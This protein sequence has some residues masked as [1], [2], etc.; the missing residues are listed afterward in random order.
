VAIGSE[1]GTVFD[2]I[3]HASGVFLAWGKYQQLFLNRPLCKKYLKNCPSSIFFQQV[4]IAKKSRILCFI[5]NLTIPWRQKYF[6]KAITTFFYVN[7][8][9][10]ILGGG[11]HFGL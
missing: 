6:R 8:L 7:I 1:L 3:V 10:G 9:G 5:K 11:A 4:I 2:K